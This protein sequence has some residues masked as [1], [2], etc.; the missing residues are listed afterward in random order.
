[1]SNCLLF[2]FLGEPAACYCWVG[3]SSLSWL[4]WLQQPVTVGLIA[5]ACHGWVGCSSLSRLGWL[6]QPVT[7][8]LVAAA[9]HGWVGCS[10]LSRLGCLQQPVT[11]GLAAAAC[12]GWVGCRSLSWLG[13][14]QQPVT[15]GLAAAAC[16][17]WVGCRHGGGAGDK[18]KKK[19]ETILDL[20][21]YLDKAVR[22]KFSGGREGKINREQLEYTDA[23]TCV[24]TCARTH[25]HLLINGHAHMLMH[26]LL[27]DF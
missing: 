7:V 25:N 5:A 15:V 6:Q 2:H 9:C 16:H 17:G 11:V 27:W 4:G 18:E 20:T 13:W 1:M 8:G 3:C 14:L 26:L 19:K 12:H 22:V 21:K 23:Q 24:C 10:S